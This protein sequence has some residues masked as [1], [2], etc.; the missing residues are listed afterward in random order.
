MQLLEK[1]RQALEDLKSEEQ[2]CIDRYTNHAAAAHDPVLAELFNTLKAEEEKHLNS[3]NQVLSG[4]EIPP[5]D[6]NDTMGRDYNPQATYQPGDN[7]AEKL[8]DS[9]LATD[10]IAGEKLVSGEYNN[11][12]FVFGDSEVRALLADIQVEEQNHA[13][14][15]YKYKVANGMA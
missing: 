1:E 2:L 3:L 13:E 10:C 6:C 5:V 15:I 9:Y 11:D 8:H 14:M 12:V 7:S 4:G